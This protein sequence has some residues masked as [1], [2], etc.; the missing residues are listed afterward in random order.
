MQLEVG[1]TYSTRDNNEQYIIV[2]KLPQSEAPY[3]FVGMKMDDASQFE[4]F[5]ADGSFNDGVKEA[6]FDLVEQSDSSYKPFAN[7]AEFKIHRTKW[8][9][10]KDKPSLVFR[11]LYYDDNGVK[12][13]ASF[14]SYQKL[15]QDYVFEN[16]LPTGKKK[17]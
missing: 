11:S 2:G 17:R 12:L 15:L 7:A 5:T 3:E 16:G 8:I 6:S 9:R 4:T 14:I 13:G 10:S 1:K